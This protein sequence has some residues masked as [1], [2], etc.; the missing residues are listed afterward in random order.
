MRPASRMRGERVLL[1]GPN[2]RAISIGP[3][4]S[5][6][7]ALA[8][9]QPVLLDNRRSGGPFRCGA[10]SPGISSELIQTART[11]WPNW[12]APYAARARQRAAHRAPASAGAAGLQAEAEYDAVLM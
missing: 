7:R 6:W 5:R 9:G 12:A 8:A 3:A 11:F 10:V 4:P 2:S 1:G